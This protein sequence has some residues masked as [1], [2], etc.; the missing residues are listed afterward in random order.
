ME[1]QK[2]SID[3]KVENH[4]DALFLHREIG[5]G[6]YGDKEVRIIMSNTS[7]IVQSHNKD[8][9]KDQTTDNFV[10]PFS[11]LSEKLIKALIK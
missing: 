1:K 10:I 7:L 8:K 11:E 9:K 4:K 6:T 3:L 2:I 5:K